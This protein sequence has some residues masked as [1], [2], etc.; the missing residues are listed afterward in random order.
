MLDGNDAYRYARRRLGFVAYWRCRLEDTVTAIRRMPE[1]LAWRLRYTIY[2]QRK[3][4]WGWRLW[5]EWS[6]T[7]VDEWDDAKCG[8]ADYRYAAQEEIYAAM[9]DA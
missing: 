9:A 1:R 5:W 2:G 8:L 6:A 7:D 4:G 3:T